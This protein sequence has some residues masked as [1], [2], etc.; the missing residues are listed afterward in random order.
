[1]NYDDYGL[2][3]V[4]T[5]YESRAYEY[6]YSFLPPEKWYP[7]PPR[8][9]TCVTDSPCPVCPVNTTGSPVDVKEWDDSRNVLQPDNINLEYIANRL[10]N[11]EQQLNKE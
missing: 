6:G 11:I 3:P 1:M 9:P 4:P 10:N 5:N 2:V 7:Q 8:A